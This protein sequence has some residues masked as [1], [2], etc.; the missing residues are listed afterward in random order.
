MK[1]LTF[2]LAGILAVLSSGNA[3]AASITQSGMYP[4]VGGTTATN[5]TDRPIVPDFNQ[6]D[7]TLGLLNSI[8]I[9]LIGTVTGSA[10]AESLDASPTTVTL[11][12]Q[13][14][15]G[16]SVG[17]TSLLQVIPT[18]AS[19]SNLT[20]FDGT[21]DFAGPSGIAFEGLMGT[22][23]GSIVL[24][25]AAMDPWIGQGTVTGLCSGTGQ[26]TGTGAGNLVTQFA[27]QAGCD[28]AI[29]YD[30]TPQPTSPI[31]TVPEPGTF[32]L[33]LLAG[34]SAFVRHRQCRI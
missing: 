11:T 16:F 10:W 34:A 27:T 9:E 20:A 12:L 5:F 13:A 15:V 30:Y 28:V 7:I 29:T 25:G 26:S 6:F 3:S 24:M 8:T 1:K 17:N 22:D 4:D 19:N 33:M 21:I 32:S 14:L 18:V 31:P 2:V 23:V